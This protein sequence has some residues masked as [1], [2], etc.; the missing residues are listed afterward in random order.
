LRK[1]PLELEQH[2][3]HWLG[4]LLKSFGEDMGEVFAVIGEQCNSFLDAEAI[5]FDD[6]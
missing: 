6:D 4:I 1:Q 2:G 3:L 5:V